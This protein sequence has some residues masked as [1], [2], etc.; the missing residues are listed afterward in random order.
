MENTGELKRR[1]ALLLDTRVAEARARGEIACQ[2]D[3][4]DLGDVFP[5][6]LWSEQGHWVH[7]HMGDHRPHYWVDSTHGHTRVT[8]AGAQCLDAPMFTDVHRR[9]LLHLRDRHTRPREQPPLR[10]ARS[11]PLL[12]V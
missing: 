5:R 10:R 12:L 3:W 11:V 9:Q 6:E 1:V 2:V 4:A 8:W 7:N